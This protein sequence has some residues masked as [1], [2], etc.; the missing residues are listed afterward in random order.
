MHNKSSEVWIKTRSIPASLP[1]RV[2]VT[3]PT[4]LKWSI[5]QVLNKSNEWNLITVKGKVVTDKNPVIMGEVAF[6]DPSGSIA[7]DIWEVMIDTIKE[8]NSHYLSNVQ[9]HIW[10]GK[11][12]KLSLHF[13]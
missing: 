6:A 11:K 2:Q 12:K 9:V 7:F 5:V 8:G 4:T 1:F 3:K 13:T 10:S